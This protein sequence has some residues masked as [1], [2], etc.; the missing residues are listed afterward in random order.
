MKASVP[1]LAAQ[2]Q[3]HVKG[4]GRLQ[5]YTAPAASCAMPG[6][7][8]LV[9]ET[10]TAYADHAGYTRVR[11]VNPRTAREVIGWVE[12]QRVAAD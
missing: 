7:F 5:F 10:V 1:V 3:R 12:A 8:I 2:A 11:Y 6:I 9:T 4:K